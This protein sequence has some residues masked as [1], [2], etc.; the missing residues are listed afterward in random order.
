MSLLLGYSY[1]HLIYNNDTILIQ[2]QSYGTTRKNEKLY[3]KG[4][5]G[6]SFLT[7]AADLK[8]K[9][10]VYD[11][12]K[13]NSGVC[14][15]WS[16]RL[17][18]ILSTLIMALLTNRRLLINHDKPC[19]LEDYLIPAHFD[20]RFNRSILLNRT[21]SYQDLSARKSEK[22]RKYLNGSL[23][24][25]NYF[26]D[27]VS[28]LRVNWDFTNEFRKRP[29][30]GNEVAWV[31]KLH[32]ADM[33]KELFH[34]FFKPSPLLGNALNELQKKY[35]K[36][37]KIA[38]A[39]IRVG[40][41]KNMPYDDRRPKIPTDDVWKYFDKLNKSEYDFFIASD[42]NEMK[43]VAKN[44]YPKNIIDTPGK[45]THIDQKGR[46]DPRA[47]FLKQ[48]L[49]FFT[50]VKCDA[51]ILTNSGFGTFAAYLRETDSD[52]YCLKGE[53][54]RPCSRYTVHKVFPGQF[55]APFQ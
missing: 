9:Y 40:G 18:G 1:K 38:C 3:L 26:H 5:I 53:H 34:F 54:L 36:R 44:R 2:E 27:D 12:S 37:P 10:I 16:D 46:N 47:G 50:L 17:S 8:Q 7:T 52:L 25:N 32:Y 49:D 39:H 24:I 43:N 6:Q 4:H 35:R 13:A 29:H 15:G 42:A 30:I 51:L 45:I 14:G 23:D 48:F 19:P 33:Y 11:C 28:F 22:L 41:N 31:T 20:W 21:K 55:L